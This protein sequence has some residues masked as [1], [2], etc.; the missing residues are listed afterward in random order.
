VGVRS[1]S[2]VSETALKAHIDAKLHVKCEECGS[3]F[4]NE[5]RLQQ[6]RKDTHIRVQKLKEQGLCIRTLACRVFMPCV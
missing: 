3:R 2:F 6:H 5:D 4:H 1:K